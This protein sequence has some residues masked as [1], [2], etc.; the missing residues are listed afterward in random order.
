MSYIKNFTWK[1]GKSCCLPSLVKTW[2]SDASKTTEKNFILNYG[3]L[4]IERGIYLHL[5]YYH[6]TFAFNSHGYQERLE[7]KEYYVPEQYVSQRR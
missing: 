1:L 2:G 4:A 7:M 5:I 6:N 3:N